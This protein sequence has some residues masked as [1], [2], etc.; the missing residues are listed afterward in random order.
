MAH[1]ENILELDEHT[2][3]AQVLQSDLPVL[4]DFWAP[5][6]AP[7]RAIAPVIEQVASDLAG[8]AVVGKVET[9]SNPELVEQYS[10]ASIPTLILFKHGKAVE[11]LVGVAS[12]QDLLTKLQA[13]AA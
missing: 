4:V 11:R 12:K 9:D 13:L 5:W 6:C 10:I 2:F 3:D 8:R 7:C 1:T